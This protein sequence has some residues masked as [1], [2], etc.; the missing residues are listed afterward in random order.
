MSA[1]HWYHLHELYRVWTSACMH[2]RVTG[3]GCMQFA[4]DEY[5]DSV[6]HTR[7]FKHPHKN[8]SAFGW[9]MDY[10]ARVQAAYLL[11]QSCSIS[12]RSF[13]D[14]DHILQICLQVTLQVVVY[15]GSIASIM[16]LWIVVWWL[17]V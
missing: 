8:C 15:S 2:G 16:Q 7:N 11:L 3:R 10:H 5:F 12:W 13:L 1:R 4:P 9:L 17:S 6:M 14:H